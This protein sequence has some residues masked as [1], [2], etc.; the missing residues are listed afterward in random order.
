MPHR[1]YKR[2]NAVLTDKVE[3]QVNEL[4]EAKREILP[5]GTAVDI[6]LRERSFDLV[7]H[8]Y[9]PDGQ[10]PFEGGLLPIYSSR[11]CNHTRNRSAI[12][13]CFKQRGRQRMPIFLLHHLQTP[14]IRADFLFGEVN[15]PALQ[16]LVGSEGVCMQRVRY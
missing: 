2:V 5:P 8:A 11:L 6:T 13:L 10:M 15:V 3:K 4:L 12:G 7:A 1:V 9:L 14:R 16:A